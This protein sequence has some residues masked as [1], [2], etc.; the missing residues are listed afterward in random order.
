MFY[1]KST[2]KSCLHIYIYV[3]LRVK[4]IDYCKFFYERK[5]PTYVYT[6]LTSENVAQC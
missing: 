6:T 5:I 4:T 2:F 3:K 1:F